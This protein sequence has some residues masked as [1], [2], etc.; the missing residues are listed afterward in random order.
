MLTRVSAEKNNK[1]TNKSVSTNT[2]HQFG[3]LIP[4]DDPDL[5]GSHQNP[6][7][8]PKTTEPRTRQK[9]AES[10]RTNEGS[11]R[12]DSSGTKS[13]AFGLEE[14]SRGKKE[15][16]MEGLKKDGILKKKL[17]TN[18]QGILQ[19][20]WFQVNKYAD[21]IFYTFMNGYVSASV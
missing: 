7:L 13:A 8:T 16:M 12:N 17:K 11:K 21:I 20:V 14:E 19:A 3:P 5:S 4:S 1:S 18:I 2:H 9:R 15:E 10:V 6:S